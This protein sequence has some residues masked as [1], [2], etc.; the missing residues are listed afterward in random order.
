MWLASLEDND[1]ADNEQYR[2]SG[3]E[4]K[5]DR[6]SDKRQPDL[7]IYEK[8]TSNRCYEIPQPVG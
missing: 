8:N 5:C 3:D 6:D 7:R 1:I 2:W 4:Q